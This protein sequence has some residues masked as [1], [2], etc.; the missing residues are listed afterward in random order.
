V[1]GTTCV[2]ALGRVMA[3]ECRSSSSIMTGHRYDDGPSKA[4]DDEHDRG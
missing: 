1:G 3:R 4:F 2:G